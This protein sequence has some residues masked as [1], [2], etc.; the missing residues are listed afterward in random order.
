MEVALEILKYTLP[1]LIVFITAILILRAMIK[2]DQQKRNLEIN[3]ANQKTILPLRLQA[4]ER[5]CMLLERISPESMIMRVNQPNMKAQQLQNE[6][7]NTIRAEFDH[8][9]SQQVYIS[10]E[11]WEMVKKARANIIQLI[12][13]ASEQIKPDASS[14]T[15]SKKILELVMEHNISPVGPALNFIKKEV[16]ELY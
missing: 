14:I 2:N 5:I 1:A 16:Q 8:N 11:A 15:L 10:H 4:Y 13:T 7:I 3:L 9:L 6:L 12:N